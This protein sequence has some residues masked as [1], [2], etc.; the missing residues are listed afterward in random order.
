MEVPWNEQFTPGN[1]LTPLIASTGNLK[2]LE[3]GL[4]RRQLSALDARRN[5]LFFRVATGPE[6]DTVNDEAQRFGQALQRLGKAQ[7]V[8]LSICLNVL[9]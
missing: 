3:A 4:Q 2:A 5:G 6:D 7:L 9:D 8:L 1:R